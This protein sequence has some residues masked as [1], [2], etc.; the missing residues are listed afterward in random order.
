M[1]IYTNYTNLNIKKPVLTIGTYDGMH[2]GHTYIM[3]QL[4]SY[5]KK[6]GG[7]SVVFSFGNHPRKFLFPEQN[8]ELLHTN[9]EKI[10]KFE[11]T[12]LENLILHQ[13]DQ[14]FANL[15]YEEFIKNIKSSDSIHT[16]TNIRKLKGHPAAFR[17]RIGD[18]RL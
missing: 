16:L 14:N 18:Y 1:N 15:N 7:E 10:Q 6:I 2:L 17:I 5:A 4:K 11:E 13:F 12:G 9:S 3:E 8:I